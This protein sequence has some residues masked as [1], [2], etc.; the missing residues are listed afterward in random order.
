V[1]E[2]ELPRF[3]E[4]LLAVRIVRLASMAIAVSLTNTGE[5]PAGFLRARPISPANR[6]A[7]TCAMARREANE[8]NLVA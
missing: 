8:I 1:V 2:T 3:A 7:T 5:Q 6:L 4:I